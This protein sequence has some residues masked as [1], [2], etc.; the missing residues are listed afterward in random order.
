MPDSTVT[1]ALTAQ[2][3]LLGYET[4]FVSS[5]GSIIPSLTT[6]HG[7]FM[8]Y[9]FSTAIVHG[10]VA[11]WASAVVTSIGNYGD[12][13]IVGATGQLV[14]LSDSDFTVFA[15]GQYGDIIN[16]GEITGHLGVGLTGTGNAFTNT[17]LVS[18]NTGSGSSHGGVSVQATNIV[19][20]NIG[21]IFGQLAGISNSLV[22]ISNLTIENSGLIS[23]IQG[24]K[25]DSGSTLSLDNSGTITGYGGTAISSNMANTDILNTGVINGDVV[26][27]STGAFLKNSGDILGD[28]FLDDS[29]SYY[30]GAR[31][32]WVSGGVRGDIG[33]D[34]IYG[35]SN[36]DYIEGGGGNDY[37]RGRAGNDVIYG[38]S[39][40]DTIRGND[41]DDEIFGGTFADMLY[42][43][44]G[45]DTIT[46]G[47][48]AD[49]INGGA[50]DDLLTGG[51]SDDVFVFNRHSGDDEITDFSNNNDKLDLSKFAA[52][53]RADLTAA[54]AIVENGAGSIID[55]TTIGG[56]GVIY[57]DDM[58]VADWTNGDLIF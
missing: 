2:Q 6:D 21:E 48:G 42:G 31:D 44:R 19:I 5:S 13:L 4:I 8:T 16:H 12:T 7:I 33:N 23:G 50:G 11:S 20:N 49:T 54:G 30:K 25:V 51:N 46:G 47:S 3:N 35:A 15:P 52:S 22:S 26:F 24:V 37:V 53:S 27:T 43:G 29:G 56:D 58:S 57:V 34:T 55:L 14:G 45:D 32:G 9:S 18:A 17:G 36:F 28:V 41:G 10:L 39:G 38:D 40:N 1:T